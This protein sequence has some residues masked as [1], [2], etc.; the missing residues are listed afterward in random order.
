MQVP[1]NPDHPMKGV[2]VRGPEHSLREPHGFA[3]SF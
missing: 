1:A 2:H 3:A